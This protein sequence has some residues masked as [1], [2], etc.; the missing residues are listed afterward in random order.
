MR[1]IGALGLLSEYQEIKMPKRSNLF[2]QLIYAIQHSVSKGEKV[3]ESK[4]L[5]DKQTGA[6]VEVD[7]V[8]DADVN[9][10][11]VVLSVEVRDR[12]RPATVEWV[13]ECIGKHATLETNKLVL[14]SSSGFTEEAISKS[15]ECGIEAIT[16]TEAQE[17]DWGDI[18]GD[19]D[20][21]NMN[22][23]VF[24]LSWNNYS[25]TYQSFVKEGEEIFISLESLNDCVYTNPENGNTG[26]LKELPGIFLRE[27]RVAR[28]IMQ[29]WIKEGK[30][31]FTINWGCPPGSLVTDP[32]G[33]QFVLEKMQ[34]FGKC[35]V[36]REPFEFKFGKF[37]DANIAHATVKD[38]VSK[39]PK[40]GEITLTLV[41]SEGGVP[42][43]ALTL[44]QPDELG[45]RVLTMEKLEDL[46]KQST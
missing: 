23:A 29:Q 17:Y 34:I 16:I 28:P 3:T 31:N 43:G 44:P 37:K 36:K 11:P 10:F 9:N 33:N 40:A 4:F 22:L 25:I 30:E 7:I 5:I 24:K 38:I 32:L 18:L 41:E 12:K 46:T 6:K 20:S 13:R 21:L 26:A 39:S 19:L 15:T 42:I 35:L 8:I 45:R 2:Q 27:A 1:Q 14:V